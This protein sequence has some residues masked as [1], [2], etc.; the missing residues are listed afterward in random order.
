MPSHEKHRTQAE[1]NAEMLRFIGARNGQ[2][3]F[4]DWYV[5]VAFYA[6]LHL[7]EAMLSAVKPT[8]TIDRP[9]MKV[10]AEDSSSLCGFYRSHSEHHVRKLIMTSSKKFD[11][12]YRPYTRLY[13]MS[14]VARYKCYASNSHD[15][16]QA[17]LLLDDVKK[18]CETLIRNKK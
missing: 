14:R 16:I 15:W 6:A 3:P 9:N 4:S 2:T 12:L 1:H 17:E 8:V 11:R 13:D 7:F 5:T 10:K 18:E